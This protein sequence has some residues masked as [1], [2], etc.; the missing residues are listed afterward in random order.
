LEKN[1]RL[2]LQPWPTVDTVLPVE[3]AEQLSAV[4][5][6]RAIDAVLVN[7]GVGV[8]KEVLVNGWVFGIPR[9]HVTREAVSQFSDD[10]IDRINPL[11]PQLDS[12]VGTLGPRKSAQVPMITTRYFNNPTAISEQRYVLV[13]TVVCR[14]TLGDK[15]EVP[16]DTLTVY[17]W[18]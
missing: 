12:R 8:A 10:C 3:R 6:E 17:P 14:D 7:A 15:C 16:L 4:S 13:Y 5:G 9:D 11:E 18:G 1:Q 2:A